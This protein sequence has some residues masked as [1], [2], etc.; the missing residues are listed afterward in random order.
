MMKKIKEVKVEIPKLL[1]GWHLMTRA[2]VPKWTHV[3]IE[4]LYNADLEYDK[5]SSAL[6]RIFR[7]DRKPNPKD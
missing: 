1:A 2:G 5:M 6:M 7:A 3:Q 4:A